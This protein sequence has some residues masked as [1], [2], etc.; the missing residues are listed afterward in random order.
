MNSWDIRPGKE[1]R[2]G[3]DKKAYVATVVVI[4]L[5]VSPTA[6]R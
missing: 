2:N 5:L 3:L 4:M 6:R 1:T